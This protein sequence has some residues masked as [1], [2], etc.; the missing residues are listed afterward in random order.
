MSG[1]VFPHS[2]LCRVLPSYQHMSCVCLPQ[3]CSGGYYWF[4]VHYLNFCLFSF[5]FKTENIQVTLTEET[6]SEGKVGF[7]AYKNYFTA[8]AH[9]FIIIF[10]I[11]VNLAAQVSKDFYFYFFPWK[12]TLLF[13]WLNKN[14]ISCK[15]TIFI[16][17]GALR[18]IYLILFILC[19][20]YCII[21]F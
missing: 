18:L 3:L 8:G 9:W 5:P 6:R 1:S 15:G 20:P 14:K 19:L 11:L 13:I 21:I 4:R 12:K 10:L 16:L 2:S 17:I 7:K